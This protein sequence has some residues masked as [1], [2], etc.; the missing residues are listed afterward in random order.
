M[1]SADPVPVPS[2]PRKKCHGYFQAEP[3]LAAWPLRSQ[4]Q[5]RWY[6]L[7]A[8]ERKQFA[9]QALDGNPSDTEAAFALYEVCGY[10]PRCVPT[11]RTRQ[12]CLGRVASLG[13]VKY[14]TQDGSLPSR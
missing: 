3:T 5:A 14:S 8:E 6:S 10:T 4:P 9:Q 12:R 13:A 1:H 2:S 11:M 7:P